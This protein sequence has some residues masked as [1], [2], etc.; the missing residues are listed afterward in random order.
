M[1]P[2]PLNAF[3]DECRLAPVPAALTIP[4][5]PRPWWVRLSVPAA[6]LSIGGVLALVLISMPGGTSQDAARQTAQALALV[7]MR[8]LP[9][10]FLM[11]VQKS[12]GIPLQGNERSESGGEGAG[13]E[14]SGNSETPP[15]LG[16]G[17]GRKGIHGSRRGN[18]RFADFDPG[19]GVFERSGTLTPCPSPPDSLRLFPCGGIPEDFC[20]NIKKERGA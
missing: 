12:S 15:K 20:T 7:Q 4:P 6:G 18:L 1:I 19:Y 5:L 10:S 13:G 3:Y 2:D 9:L 8:K 16:E 17:S 14:G 11:V